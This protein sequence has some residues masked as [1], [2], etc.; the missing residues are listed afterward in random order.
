MHDPEELFT[1][2]LAVVARWLVECWGY[3]HPREV[4]YPKFPRL[5]DLLIARDLTKILAEFDLVE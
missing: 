4:S 1:D 3:I 5:V 2:Y